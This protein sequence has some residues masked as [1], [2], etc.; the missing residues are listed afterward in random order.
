MPVVIPATKT[1]LLKTNPDCS[2]ISESAVCL[3][4]LLFC[5][6]LWTWR[7]V[8]GSVGVMSCVLPVHLVLWAVAVF[9]RVNHAVV[10]EGDGHC[11]SRRQTEER[12]HSGSTQ[13]GHRSSNL[14]CLRWT[15]S[16][17]GEAGCQTR[18][19]TASAASWRASGR[20][21][22]RKPRLTAIDPP[23]NWEEEISVRCEGRK[24]ARTDSFWFTSINPSRSTLPEQ[25]APCF[26]ADLCDIQP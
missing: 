3:P 26:Y 4:F 8:T 22:C 19:Q 2:V 10:L 9:V 24:E 17:L 18:D 15:S 16:P 23:R 13:P 7:H 20:W 11:R 6:P 12:V 14:Y 5:P 1:N 21:S 25:Q